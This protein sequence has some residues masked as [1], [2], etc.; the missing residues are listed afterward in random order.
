MVSKSTRIFLI[1][2][3]AL[4]AMVVTTFLPGESVTAQAAGNPVSYVLFA[5]DGYIQLPDGVILY[6]YG[7]IGGRSTDPVVYQNSMVAPPKSPK[8]YVPGGLVDAAGTTGGA[9]AGLNWQ[10]AANTP[11]CLTQLAGN[12][13]F[14]APLI[15]AAVG[16]AVTITLKNLGV[17]TKTAPND[18]HSI[19]LHG[20]DVNAANDGVPETSVGAI[21]AN[22]AVPGAGNVI[23]YYF[24]P[25]YAGTYMYHCHQ[26]ADIHVQMGMFGALV[27]YEPTDGAYLHWFD[28]VNNPTASGG[29]LMGHTWTKEN[30]L[31]LSEFDVNQHI[32]EQ[33]GAGGNA[34]FNPVNYHPQYWSI[35]GLS[36][37]QTI[38]VAPPVIPAGT[39]NWFDQIWIK[40]HP[41]YD[42]LIVGSVGALD[43]VLV[44]MINMGFETQPMHMHGFHG[45]IIGSD[46]RAWNW[47]PS[48]T[49]EGLEKNT[50]TIG[51]GETYEWLLDYSV[52]SVKG[53]TGN[54]ETGTE[55][56]YFNNLGTCAG[57][58]NMPVPNGRTDCPAIPDPGVVPPASYIGGPAVGPVIPNPDGGSLPGQLLT[59][60]GVTPFT[61]QLFPFHNHD[62]YKATN[63]GVYPGGQFTMIATVP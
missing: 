9:C 15:R 40:A 25:E 1:I 36:F 17:T 52:W 62:D 44:R 13:Q 19:H 45:K 23:Y 42:P 49:G 11:A 58:L 63:N 16:D 43:K 39:T 20:L 4:S 5:T 53:A 38:H 61:G 41:G 60:G 6:M 7:F 24:S 46:Q 12:S 10:Q 33:Q 3:L 35:N 37:P 56:R 14:P 34:A 21:P 47:I 8:T 55:S 26:E 29:T 31:L 51:S 50:V 59:M 22:M 27:V 18:P 57:I 2:T 30:I 32:S 54:Y 48:L 28:P